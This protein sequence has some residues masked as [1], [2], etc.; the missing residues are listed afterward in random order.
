MDPSAH[1]V[2]QQGFYRGA[3]VTGP[4]TDR[5]IARY[6]KKGYYSSGMVEERKAQRAKRSPRAKVKKIL[7]MFK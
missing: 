6:A 1:Y 3:M 5:A 2:T 7:A 4:L